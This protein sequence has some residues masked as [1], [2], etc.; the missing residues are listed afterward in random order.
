MVVIEFQKLHFV[1]AFRTIQRVIAEREEDGSPPLSK[2]AVDLKFFFGN[3][4]VQFRINLT[5]PCIQPAIA[6]HFKMFF[7]DVA[8]ETFYEIH[9]RQSFLH[10]LV[11]FMAVIMESNGISI[12]PINPGCGYDGSAKITTNIFRNDFRVA[13]IGL[14]ID[15]ETMFVLAVAFGFYFFKGRSYFAFHFIE[16]SCAESISQIVVVKVF[17]MAPEAVITVTAFG[18]ETVDVRIPFEIPAKSMEDHDVAGSKIFGMV[19]VKKH[20]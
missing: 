11:I 4:T 5:V 19:Q 3:D 12:I 20:P 18:K 16:E 2:T 14:G 8:D 17:Y 15:I 9:D 7:R 10:I 6:D 13:E 1:I